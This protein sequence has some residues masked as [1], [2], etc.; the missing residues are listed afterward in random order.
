MSALMRVCVCVCIIS[1]LHIAYVLVLQCEGFF[2]GQFW[3]REGSRLKN[4]SNESE[5]YKLMLNRAKKNLR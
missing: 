3:L 4:D 2:K 1:H 5:A